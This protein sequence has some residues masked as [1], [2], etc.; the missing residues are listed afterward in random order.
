MHK[1]KLKINGNPEIPNPEMFFL[2][3]SLT[4]VV[5]ESV[6]SGTRS[7]IALC[8]HYVEFKKLIGP[9]HILTCN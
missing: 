4:G 2:A 1:N 7:V 3:T 9:G 5:R 8:K 6:H